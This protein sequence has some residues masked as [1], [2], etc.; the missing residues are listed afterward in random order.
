[1][2]RKPTRA[3][4]K[5]QIALETAVAKERA[6]QARNQEFRRQAAQRSEAR[7]SARIAWKAAHPE[8]AARQLRNGKQAALCAVLLCI[9]VGIVA[10]VVHA[11]R[12]PARQ[13]VLPNVTGQPLDSAESALDTA[14]VS[15]TTSGGGIFGIVEKAN[16]T[17]C[18]EDPPAGAISASVALKVD[19]YCPGVSPPTTTGP[20]NRDFE[21]FEACKEFVRTRLKAP[22]TATWRD[23]TGNQVTYTGLND[24]PYIVRASVDAEN[25]F[26]VPLRQ[27]YECTV[28]RD[29]TTGGFRLVDL[30][31]G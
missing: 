17:V 28:T 21:A 18:S 10:L 2:T 5:R 23:P 9:L 22:T 1:M 11:G 14:G 12:S 20:I 13:V 4:V 29:P 7:R 25:S 30:K 3:Q 15:H 8:E 16:W 31:I 19:R 24:G 6:N 27:N 26:G